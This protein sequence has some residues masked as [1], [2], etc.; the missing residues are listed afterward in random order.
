MSKRSSV[1]TPMNWLWLRLLW[2]HEGKLIWLS[3]VFGGLMGWVM[4]VPW[5][6]ANSTMICSTFSNFAVYF[7]LFWLMSLRRIVLWIVSYWYPKLLPLPI[8]KCFWF[9]D[10]EEL[11]RP[12]WFLYLACKHE[13]KL[14][15]GVSRVVSLISLKR[16]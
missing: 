3:P 14:E 4:S 6:I 10:Q 7:D 9:R 11:E 15:I 12:F 1:L 8:E 5:P 16:K 13:K 2:T